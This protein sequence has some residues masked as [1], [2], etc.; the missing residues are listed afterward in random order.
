MSHGLLLGGGY[1]GQDA[2]LIEHDHSGPGGKPSGKPWYV[3]FGEALVDPK[4][5]VIL[6][7]IV[8]YVITTTFSS[9][10]VLS[11]FVWGAD[12]TAPS[13]TMDPRYA[14]MG[15]LQ[16]LET[17]AFPNVT[18]FVEERGVCDRTIAARKQAQ[19]ERRGLF[20]A[21][22]ARKQLEQHVHMDCIIDNLEN[23]ASC[24]SGIGLYDWNTR[25]AKPC[26]AV[27]KSREEWAQCF[28]ER[29]YV[30]LNATCSQEQIE[31]AYDNCEADLGL[32]VPFPDV[33]DPADEILR[34]SLLQ[35][36]QARATYDRN[37]VA[38]KLSSVS[39]L[40][41]QLSL[42]VI[43]VGN[44]EL[45]VADIKIQFSDYQ[46][47][48]GDYLD[49]ATA[50]IEEVQAQVRRAEQAISTEV[51]KLRDQVA[52]YNV[53]LEAFYVVQLKGSVQT[54]VNGVLAP[55]QNGLS[56][57]GSLVGH[58]TDLITFDSLDANISFDGVGAFFESVAET[59]GDALAAGVEAAFAFAWKI[60]FN[61][62]LLDPPQDLLDEIMSKTL[63][64]QVD[65]DNIIAG[66]PKLSIPDIDYTPADFPPLPNIPTMDI[67]DLIP[68]IPPIPPVD[69]LDWF[70]TDYDPPEVFNANINATLP[71]FSGIDIPF[72]TTNLT[73][74][75]TTAITTPT[76]LPDPTATLPS[77]P[78]SILNFLFFLDAMSL[79]LDTIFT[80]ARLRI[81][82]PKAFDVFKTIG[83]KAKNTQIDTVG[84]RK[85]IN[86]YL[87]RFV[88]FLNCRYLGLM[89]LGITYT[90]FFFV[91]VQALLGPTNDP[92]S[93]VYTQ[94][95]PMAFRNNLYEYKT[96]NRFNSELISVTNACLSD[97]NDAVNEI[98]NT[99]VLVANNVTQLSLWASTLLAS[100]FD[101][102]TDFDS[103]APDE[104]EYYIGA[105]DEVSY[106]RDGSDLCDCPVVEYQPVYSSQRAEAAQAGDTQFWLV[107]NAYILKA[108]YFL[109]LLILL[110]LA[111]NQIIKLLVLTL[112]R[113]TVPRVRLT[114]AGNTGELGD[115]LPDY[116]KEMKDFY[117]KRN[118]STGLRV[119]FILSVY[120]L[121]V[122]VWVGNLRVDNQLASPGT[123]AGCNVDT[124]C[125]TGDLCSPG[126]CDITKRRCTVTNIVCD[127]GDLC[128]RDVCYT[129][130]GCVFEALPCESDPVAP[131]SVADLAPCFADEAFCDDD[132]ACTTDSCDIDNGCQYTSRS[133]DD[134]NDCTTDSCDSV[135]G[136]QHTPI[137]C[138][139][140]DACTIDLCDPSGGCTTE[141]LDCDDGDF[142]TDD[143]CSGGVCN[144]VANA[145]DCNDGVACTLDQCGATGCEYS[146]IHA[147]CDDGDACTEDVCSALGC[148]NDPIPGCVNM[149]TNPPTVD[150]PFCLEL[151]S[152]CDTCNITGGT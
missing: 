108:H 130:R 149:A 3:R 100:R 33:G 37:Y 119:C 49:Q 62:D 109:G 136:C 35:R 124:D 71:D 95:G 59:V 114:V 29:V 115:N 11:G 82:T 20:A 60:G 38:R 66:L 86:R 98:I 141:A 90:A 5:K 103:W 76:Y 94:G 85:A 53:D 91:Y 19:A 57:M 2:E 50:S 8:A 63:Q 83:S 4:N 13:V 12:F 36:V 92:T 22:S 68:P 87:W 148:S 112:S 120:A 152:Y 140:G 101:S 17:N 129:D 39:D 75:N 106:A 46:L 135:L 139:D 142:C 1:Q 118:R 45:A 121:V 6:L 93:F 138:D 67:P 88:A 26:R 18:R 81:R 15:A 43:D 77:N 147:E 102:S 145:V 105:P 104:S 128:T 48:L 117:K 79:L 44:F 80:L 132:D 27:D 123:Y 55:I 24:A 23:D 150:P 64:I 58:V 74:Y 126:I 151:S 110:R 41:S 42:F 144:S 72:P 134:N 47:E 97:R 34:S 99:Q 133:C 28:R 111:R 116:E 56:L 131:E 107:T 52:A 89:F 84:A 69:L 65:L 21:W 61:L 137:V 30:D 14:E 70:G 25:I 143:S 122:A 54:F 40:V 32:P 51:Q 10:S 127:D 16:A 113:Y 96:Y 78:T 125:D 9:A 7:F 31:E 73:T 146:F